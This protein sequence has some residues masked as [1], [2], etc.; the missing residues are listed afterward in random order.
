MIWV[1]R[2]LMAVGLLTCIAGVWVVSRMDFSK[3]EPRVLSEYPNA[4]WRG[5]ADGGQYIEVTR[6]EPP[7][8]FVQVRNDDGS[9]WDEGWLKFGEKNGE[10]LTANDVIAFAGEGVIYLQQCKVLSAD[11]AKA[12]Q[13]R[14]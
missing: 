5:G 14:C 1:K 13:K 8:Y 6:S 2:F 11:R 10:P 7:Y 12:E 3:A 4:K 9:L